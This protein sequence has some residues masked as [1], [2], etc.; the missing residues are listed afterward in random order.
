M[1]VIDQDNMY[2]NQKHLYANEQLKSKDQI[3]QDPLRISY[4]TTN[5]L[6]IIKNA[7]NVQADV[8]F[9]SDDANENNLF[10]AF[11]NPD[12]KEMLKMYG[13]NGIMIDSTHGTNPYQ[14]QL[15]TLMILDD[16]YEGFPSK[17]KGIAFYNAFFKKCNIYP[18]KILCDSHVKKNLF[19]NLTK[20]SN[21]EIRNKVKNHLTQLTNELNETTFNTMHE[22]FLENLLIDPSTENYG[23][24][25]GTHHAKRPVHCYRK[26][27]PK[28]TVMS[29]EKWHQ[30][31][32]YN[33]SVGGRIQQRLDLS[34]NNVIEC[35][36]NKF[37][38]RL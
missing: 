15:T 24:Y 18:N 11:M 35:L 14:M 30:D 7:F 6:H 2:Q 26:D 16:Y 10:L 8:I 28:N 4:T 31:L 20:I 21:L 19:Q 29:L 5:D 17:S 13:N 23:E 25:F 3:K 32:K 33:S 36:R 27:F 22:K 1:V 12:Q 38:R 34:I 9:H 37:L